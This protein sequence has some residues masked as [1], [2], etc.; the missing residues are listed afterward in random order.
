MTTAYMSYLDWQRELIVYSKAYE[1]DSDHSKDIHFDGTNP[2]YHHGLM[3][4]IG[5]DVAAY[6]LSPSDSIELESQPCAALGHY[7]IY[8]TPATV[9]DAGWELHSDNIMDKNQ[10]HGETLKLITALTSY[11]DELDI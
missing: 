5:Y 4:F 7:D 11:L 3:G 1:T 9:I 8:L 10:D 2:S 6:E